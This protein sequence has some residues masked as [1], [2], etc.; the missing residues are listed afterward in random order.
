MREIYQLLGTFVGA[1]IGAGAGILAHIG[2][3]ALWEP[4]YQS[5]VTLYTISIF[6]LGGAGMLGGGYLA[7]W[8]TMKV[9]K[10]RRRKERRAKTKFGN[11]RRK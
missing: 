10:V 1:I 2:L 6:G 11:K 5:H 7:L 9:Y 3:H 8:I 4:V